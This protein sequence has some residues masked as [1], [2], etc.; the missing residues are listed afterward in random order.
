MRQ[1]YVQRTFRRRSPNFKLLSCACLL[2]LI[3][4]LFL[5][6]L[7]F[8]AFY[9]ATEVCLQISHLR[10]ARAISYVRLVYLAHFTKQRKSAFKSHTF[11]L[12]EPFP[13]FGSFTCGI[14]RN[15]KR[16]ETTK[17]IQPLVFL[18]SSLRFRFLVWGNLLWPRFDYHADL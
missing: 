16:E 7:K 11:V 4:V 17:Q 10:I 15:K 13:T 1:F 8:G 2:I 14:N 18:N 3:Y 12:Q 6:C 5:R 9:R